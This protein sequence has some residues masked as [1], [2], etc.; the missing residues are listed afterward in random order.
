[1]I[2]VNRITRAMLCSTWSVMYFFRSNTARS[3]ITM[4]ST[5]ARPEKI[6]PATK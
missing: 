2:E 3:G 6:A 1:M 5:I 4:V